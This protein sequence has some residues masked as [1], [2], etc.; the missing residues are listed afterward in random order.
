MG[1]VWNVT[2]AFQTLRPDGIMTDSR[3]AELRNSRPPERG[4]ITRKTSLWANDNNPPQG[5]RERGQMKRALV[6]G[7]ASPLRGGD[8]H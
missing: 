5:K 3:E 1:E 2:A 4:G 6:S 7:P 8:L